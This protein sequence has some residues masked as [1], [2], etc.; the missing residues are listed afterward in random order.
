MRYEAYWISPS[1]KIIP[2]ETTH[3]MSIFNNPKTYGLDMVTIVKTYRKYNEPL[4]IEGRAR[5]EIMTD[6]MKNGWI[7]VRH[8]GN[9]GWYF[10]IIRL[11]EKLKGNILD[12]VS[13]GLHDGFITKNTNVSIG[14]LNGVMSSS[15]ASDL[16]G[17]DLKLENSMSKKISLVELLNENPDKMGVDIR[18]DDADAHPFGY[19]NGIF[20]FGNAGDT[21]YDAG[22]KYFK[23]GN[24]DRSNQ[25]FPGRIWTK[26]NLISFWKYPKTLN[27]WNK[28][29]AD[30]KKKVAGFNESSYKLEIPRGGVARNDATYGAWVNKRTGE[31]RGS[32]FINFAEFMSKLKNTKNPKQ[33]PSQDKG[34]QHVKSPL[35][36][37]KQ[38][39]PM[40]L[41][42]MKRPAGLSRSQYYALAGIGAEGTIKL[43]SILKEVIKK[44]RRK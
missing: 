38:E 4:G 43:K 6:L 23:V 18:Y 39:V 30:I 16:I 44:R 11:S 28:F 36:K 21:H 33:I 12:F 2:T 27:D 15:T 17:G 13:K 22:Y 10:E 7:R 20:M 35:L 5:E 8:V 26:R 34:Q 42:S 3:I 14:Q 19:L 1:G 25:T 9:K 31:Y 41:G 32:N 37:N 29:I 24:V 40:G